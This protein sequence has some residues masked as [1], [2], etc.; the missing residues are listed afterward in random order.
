MHHVG[1]AIWLANL[2]VNGRPNNE[3]SQNPTGNGKRYD[4]SKEE[5]G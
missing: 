1:I 5:I 3:A 4:R 2:G